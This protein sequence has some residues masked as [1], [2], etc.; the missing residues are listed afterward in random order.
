MIKYKIKEH[1]LIKNSTSNKEGGKDFTLINGI[2]L[3]EA[4][5]N[6]PYGRIDKRETGIGATTLELS[7]KRHSII[8]QPLRITAESKAEGKP[9][10]FYFGNN[11]N[12]STGR[13]RTH[14]LDKEIGLR[15]YINNPKWQF[16]KISVVADS[17]PKLI[18][19]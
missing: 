14:G 12:K 19:E 13:I 11:R 16:K 5:E 3:S 7:S 15:E 1:S 6:L 18:N 4:I 2:F 8:V 17:L 10:V 9:D